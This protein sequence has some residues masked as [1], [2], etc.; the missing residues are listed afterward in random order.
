[1]TT[2]TQ[3]QWLQRLQSFLN[4]LLTPIIK[5]QSDRN[6]YIDANAMPIWAS[7]FTHE[8]WSPSDNYEDLEFLGDAVL[9]AVFPK[10]LM[11]RFPYLHKGEY[12]ELN[13]AYMSKMMQ[14]E[15]A[16]KMG[17]SEHIRVKGINRAILNL[18]TDV[19]ESFFGAL[20]TISDNVMPGLGFSNC[21]NMIV[22][23]FSTIEIDESKGRGSAKTQVI[24][25]FS[26]FD[27]PA[28]DEITDGKSVDVVI[29]DNLL[30]LIK[31]KGIN[32]TNTNI[33]HGSHIKDTNAR[34]MAYSQAIEALA[35]YGLVTINEAD[36]ATANG[37][38][39]F[40]VKLTPAHR[41]FL[42]TY[43]VNIQNPSIGIGRAA[44]KK[45]AE[46]LAYNQALDTLA[47]LGITTEWAEEA[48]QTRDFS[49][50][51]ITPN[52]QRAIERLQR[53]GYQSMYFFIPRKTGTKQGAI[54]QLVG[55]RPNGKNEVISYTFSA[56]RSNSF[57]NA[58]ALVVHQYA[59]GQQM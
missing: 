34:N 5:D 28:P 54:V 49:D 13:I 26:R 36:V 17:L 40:A 32:I 6:R 35:D 50:Q 27:L 16:R 21:Y 44:T 30:N 55:V 8:T 25:M 14:A 15:L 56:D 47:K 41:T 45:E 24:Q 43:N 31:S 58:K 48:K 53:E 11:K 2:T 51:L 10:Y 18:E 46:Y 4:A 52:L 22:H 59:S 3:V 29:N 9:K 7:A 42:R 23:L 57:R 20:D 12:T 33:G 1:M 37:S 39:D 38:I 19:F